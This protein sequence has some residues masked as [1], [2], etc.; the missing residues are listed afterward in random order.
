MTIDIIFFAVI[1]FRSVIIYSLII[2]ERET[3]NRTRPSILH[4]CGYPLLS[5]GTICQ[6]IHSLHHHYNLSHSLLIW[7]LFNNEDMYMMS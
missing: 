2:N 1:I 4:Y 5:G 3:T 7:Y 6:G